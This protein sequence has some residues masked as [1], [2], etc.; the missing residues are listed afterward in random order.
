MH[1]GNPDEASRELLG[2]IVALIANWSA[3][4]TQG[5][6][7]REMG[8]DIAESDVRALYTIGQRAD[9]IRPADLAHELRLSRPTT[10]KAIARLTATGVIAKEP[11]PT[12]QR[13]ARLL[14]TPSGQA[15]YGRLVDAGVAMI[16]RAVEG[17]APEETATVAGVVRRLMRPV[18]T[19]DPERALEDL[20]GCSA[21]RRTPPRGANAIEGE[22]S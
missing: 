12:D 17:L 8:L 18:P 7:A 15:A 4:N 6:I 5:A 13:S 20:D 1:S 11:S 16:E 19:A 3:S 21:A 2:A 10:S 22:P 9:G 14:L